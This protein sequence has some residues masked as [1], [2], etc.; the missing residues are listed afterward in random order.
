MILDPLNV[1]GGIVLPNDVKDMFR[2][3]TVR[4][5]GFG[6]LCENN[7]RE[8]IPLHPGDKVML[9][10]SNAKGRTYAT[11]QDDGVEV[12]LLNFTDILGII[13]S[14]QNLPSKPLS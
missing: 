7:Q 12:A 13:V 6:R 8:Q 3:G 4:A 10:A 9:G 11:I 1:K 5:V 14:S 2:T